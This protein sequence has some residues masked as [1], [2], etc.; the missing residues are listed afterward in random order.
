MR[1]RKVLL[2][3]L[4]IILIGGAIILYFVHHQKRRLPDNLYN[5]FRCGRST[6]E[7][8]STDKYCDDYDLYKKD[9]AAGII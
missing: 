9:H 1:N 3:I 8:L 6:L 7:Y 4:A 2:A 5:Q